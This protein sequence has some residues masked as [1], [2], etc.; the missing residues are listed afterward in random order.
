[1][2]SLTE[3]LNSIIELIQVVTGAGRGVGLALVQKLAQNP[4]NKIV[5]AVRDTNLAADHPL[6]LLLAEKSDAIAL[7]K[8]TSANE[9]D[10]AA[11][12]EVVKQKFGKVDVIIANAGE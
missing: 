8:L 6:A 12:A 10:N 5:A 7:V 2:R 1:V 11:A 3:E 4:S 9:A